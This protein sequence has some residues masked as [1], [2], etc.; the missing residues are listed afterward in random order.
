MLQSQNF[1][2]TNKCMSYKA[3]RENKILVIFLYLQ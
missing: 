1:N 2:V 3:I